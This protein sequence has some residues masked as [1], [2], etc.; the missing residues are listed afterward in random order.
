MYV[1][2]TLILD[3]LY[4]GFARQDECALLWCDEDGCLSLGSPFTRSENGIWWW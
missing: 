3:F 1:S 2:N 4:I